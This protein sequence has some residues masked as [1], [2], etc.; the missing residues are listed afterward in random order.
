MLRDLNSSLLGRLISFRF[1]GTSSFTRASRASL[2]LMHCDSNP[3]ELLS[4]LSLSQPPSSVRIFCW[5]KTQVHSSCNL[6]GVWMG[7]GWSWLKRTFCLFLSINIKMQ[8]RNFLCD[9]TFSVLCGTFFLLFVSLDARLYH[10]QNQ[11]IRAQRWILNLWSGINNF[12]SLARCIALAKHSFSWRFYLDSN[13]LSFLVSSFYLVSFLLPTALAFH[14]SRCREWWRKLWKNSPPPREG[15]KFS[16][17][18]N[19]HHRRQSL[20]YLSPIATPRKA[21]SDPCERGNS[22]GEQKNSFKSFQDASECHG[23]RWVLW[24]SAKMAKLLSD[25]DLFVN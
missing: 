15:K 18:W 3:F 2:G 17:R 19:I 23:A 13:H 25:Y 14:P 10:R 16:L 11:A 6:K 24:M 22:K 8:T 21:S 12:S 1:C 7:E 9:K 20:N 4:R 5:H